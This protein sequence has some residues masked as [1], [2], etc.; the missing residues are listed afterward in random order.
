MA[1]STE[2]IRGV[3]CLEG[4]GLDPIDPVFANLGAAP[5]VTLALQRN[6]AA[7]SADGALV[8]RTGEHTGRSAKDKYIVDEPGVSDGVWWHPGNSRMP[9]GTF[10]RIAETVRTHLNRHLLFVQDLY[11]GADPRHRIRVRLVTTHAWHALFARNMFIRPSAEELHGF[12]P[13][14]V[15]LHAPE[16]ALDP[17]RFD[18]RSP[19]AIAL[20]FAKKM[21]VIAGTFY[22]GE[23]KKSIFTVMN[24]LL[25]AEGVLPM[26]CSANIGR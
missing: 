24:W 10:E 16:L 21:V 23:I 13:D 11:A 22:A 14:Y 12:E 2:T 9:A 15:I 3:R 7:L 17:A 8:A 20:S 1:S 5:L 19:T 6:E 25:P 4:T 18:L 26:H